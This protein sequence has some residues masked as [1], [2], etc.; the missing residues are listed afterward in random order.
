MSTSWWCS[1]LGMDINRKCDFD[2]DGLAMTMSFIGALPTNI[3][4]TSEPDRFWSQWW[5][6]ERHECH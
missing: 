5:G 4:V 2:T 1:V 6:A 3:S